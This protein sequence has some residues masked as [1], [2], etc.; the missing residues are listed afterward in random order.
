MILTGEQE[1]QALAASKRLLT[2]A[3]NR[4]TVGATRA[5]ARTWSS[6]L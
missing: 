5:W 3:T 2:T 4:V 1:S 6:Y